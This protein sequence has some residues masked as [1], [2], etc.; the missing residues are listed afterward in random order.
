MLKKGLALLL[1]LILLPVWAL[2]AEGQHFHL[3]FEMNADAYPADVQDIMPG[4]A[5]LVN[6][7]TLEGTLLTEGGEFDLRAELT[8]SGRE[9]TRTALQLFS[10]AEVWNFSSSLLGDTVVSANIPAVLEFC[11]KTYSHMGV[12]L[13]RVA[14]WLVPPVHTY[15]LNAVT[16]AARPVLFAQEGSR[17]VSRD[18]LMELAGKLADIAD[19]D[20][21]FRFWAQGL[22]ME[23]DHDWVIL[24]AMMQ[25]PEWVESFVPDSGIEITVDETSET[26]VAGD[27]TLLRRETNLSG[28]QQLTVTLPPLPDGT[29]LT[30]DAALQ[31][32]GD[33]LHGSFELVV[34]DGWDE[35]MLRL[36]ADGSLPASLPVTRPFFL[37][38]EAEGAAVSDEGVHLYFEGEGDGHTVILRQLTPDHAAT[39]LTV[40]AALEPARGELTPKPDPEHD[41]GLMNLESSSLRA[42]MQRIASPLVRGLLPLIAQAPASSCQTLMNLL[43]GSGIFSLLTD[44]FGGD[45]EDD[46]WDEDEAWDEEWDDEEY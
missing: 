23:S 13:Q 36:H 17:T 25:L 42:L 39:M 44:G 28:A 1:C 9:R 35:L 8:L 32:D 4:I 30:L 33:L 40:T 43:E 2:A 26:W 11:M 37:T 16:G 46:E 29:V 3:T 18:A 12:P 19:T 14:I 6:E 45:A 41:V 24:D 27:V 5:D 15:G 34:I 7:V 31:P 20:M 38:W 21:P 10:T 22:A